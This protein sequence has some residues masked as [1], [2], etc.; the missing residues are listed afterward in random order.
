MIKTALLRKNNIIRR[1]KKEKKLWILFSFLCLRLI[2]QT[3]ILLHSALHLFA[4]IAYGLFLT[5]SEISRVS[6]SLPPTNTQPA[7]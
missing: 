2:S 3:W 1:E 5:A 7:N 6:L 4:Q